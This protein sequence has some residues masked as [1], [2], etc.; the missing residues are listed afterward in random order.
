MK[1][2]RFLIVLALWLSLSLQVASPTKACGPFLIEPIFVFHQSPDLPF[3]EFTK[4]NIG[5]IQPTFGRKTLVI[6]YRYLNGGWF[7]DDEQAALVEALKGTAPEGDG[8]AAVKTWI[9]TRQEIA[10]KEEN[11]PEIYTER[12]YGGYDFFPNCAK[13]AFEVATATLKDRV[14]TYGADNPN[15]RAWL[16]AQDIVFQHCQGGGALPE[17]LGP[18]SPTWLRKDRDYQIA[19]ALLY[20]LKFDEARARF[21]KIA[22]DVESQWQGTAEYLVAR[23][24]VRQASLTDDEKKKRAAYDEAE[25]R[26]R[27]LAARRTPLTDA[28][29]KLLG[30]IQYRVHPESRVRELA[31][32][33]SRENG[34]ANLKQNLIDYVWLLDKLEDRILKEEEKRRK[35]AEAA[36]QQKEKGNPNEKTP[37]QERS[38][39][40]RAVEKGELIQIMLIPKTA[41]GK[42]DLST[43]G[44]LYF[45]PEITETEVVKQFETKLGRPLMPE[46]NEQLHG[47]YELEQKARAARLS[48]NNRF[49][50]E[51]L[52]EHE[53]C[54]NY[55]DCA[56]LT[57]NLLPDYLIGDDLTDWLFTARTEDPSAYDHAV[58][59]YR[60]TRSTAWLVVALTKATR[61]SARVE[62]L[63]LDAQA[64][65]RNSRAFPTITYH[66]IRIKTEQGKVA[67]ARKL[68]DQILAFQF[69]DLPMSARN[70]L[71]EQRVRL[72]DNV[73]DFLRFGQRRAVA[74]SY[75]GSLGTMRDL[76]RI[77]KGHWDLY[78]M[79]RAPNGKEPRQSREEYEQA[80][81]DEYKDLLPWDDRVFFDEQ[82]IEIINWHFPLVDLEQAAR[83]PILP[84]YVRR[85]FA[86]AVWTRAIVLQNKEVADRIAPEVVK[87][88][89]EMQE[90]FEPYLKAKTEK[91]KDRAALYVLL[92]YSSLSPLLTTGI[93]ELTAS[94]D[95]EYYFESAWWCTPSN[96]EYDS[97]EERDVPKKVSKPVFLSMQQTDAARHERAALIAV[98]DGRSY[99]G[100]RVIE[101]AKESPKDP[102]IPEALFIAAEANKA[103][104]YGCQAWEGDEEIEKEAGGILLNQYS[105]SSWAAKLLAEAR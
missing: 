93:P 47:M 41:D 96:T 88:A 104:K 1:F 3:R 33:L 56:R 34:D 54:D 40:D 92:K 35:E 99:L 29:Q 45:K 76:A 44:M 28:A 61:A 13:N 16:N 24:L 57:L 12:Q 62:R 2:C 63:M 85:S 101:W 60:A 97:K 21:E 75:D 83:N 46:E 9:A 55:D 105:Q 7:S 20:S 6:A 36:A 42:S 31:Q 5:I 102:R 15:V 23:T 84:E 11:A 51:G 26:L 73:T 80:I 58:S 32:S 69:E 86:L 43:M 74:F 81:D 18:G 25:Q 19:A 82:T 79:W 67:E 95:A 59:Q 65:D 49:G 90:V 37:E 98:G 77:Q 103:Y 78:E 70:Q 22:T 72:S 30:L 87:L 91:E 100:K 52:T 68:S 94:G 48:P 50:R 89:P 8:A 71:L 27:I 14:A 39:N 10:G 4:G 53:G 38:E 64:T 66:L 17:E